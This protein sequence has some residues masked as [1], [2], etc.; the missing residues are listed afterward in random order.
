MNNMIPSFVRASKALTATAAF[1]LAFASAPQ[2]LNAQSAAD[3]IKKGDKATQERKG[4]DALN[5]YEEAIKLDSTNLE[6]MKK[7]VTTAVALSEFNLSSRSQRELTSLSE[8]YAKYVYAKEPEKAE[9]QF[10][11]AQALGRSALL[12]GQMARLKH[13]PTIYGLATGCLK[14]EPKH[15]G[16]AHI[17]GN[18][19]AEVMRL[20]SFEFGMAKRMM[21]KGELLD[22]ASWENAAKYL[23][24]AEKN[25]PNR[26]V[27]LFSLG[28]MYLDKKDL[29]EA[30][31][32]FEKVKTAPL[33]EFND[34]MYRQQS[35]TYLARINAQLK[36]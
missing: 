15:A 4:D 11:L 10:V 8:K 12:G 28:K 1:A 9:S 17:L 7:F 29:A 14:A 24:Q 13:S 26:S 22:S 18:W 31:T 32:Y 20:S 3:L 34:E 35:D 23:L 6:A 27:N 5:A 33:K 19:H 36:S 2:M 21:E 25:D 30:K 16:C